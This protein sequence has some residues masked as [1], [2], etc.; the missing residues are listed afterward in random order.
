MTR[1]LRLL[2]VLLLAATGCMPKVTTVYVLRHAEKAPDGHDPPL[3]DAG[4]ARAEALERAIPP[5]R[6]DVVYATQYLRTQETV[7]PLAAAAGLQPEVYP[8][9]HVEQLAKLI[10]TKHRNQTVVVC[11]HS[12]T[13]GPILRALG[14]HS[15]V[16]LAEDDYGDLFVV[17]IGESKVSMQRRHFGR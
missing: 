5:K 6:V 11:G 2:L 12:N 13:V 10:R 3:S 9:D 4:Q 8:A 16:P 17:T 7:Y 14:V 15:K 1:R